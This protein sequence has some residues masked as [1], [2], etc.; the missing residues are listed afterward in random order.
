MVLHHVKSDEGYRTMSRTYSCANISI[1]YVFDSSKNWGVFYSG[2]YLPELFPCSSAV[3]LLSS[4]CRV[5]R[6]HHEPTVCTLLGAHGAAY[7][8]TNTFFAPW[9]E[10][11]GARE[12]NQPNSG[13][14]NIS[15]QS[16]HVTEL[17][18]LLQWT[19]RITLLGR[20]F[21][22]ADTARMEGCFCLGCIIC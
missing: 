8:S 5:R 10:V 3:I 17:A 15:R 13:S 14:I 4:V 6:T 19:R 12:N 18:L 22:A 11:A 9:C 16:L 21:V 2:N 20:V 1:Q 7:G